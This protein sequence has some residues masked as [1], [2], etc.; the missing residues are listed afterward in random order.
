MTVKKLKELQTFLDKSGEKYE[1]ILV[2]LDPEND[3]A[4]DVATFRKRNKIEN[5]DWH[6]I[7]ADLEKTKVLTKQVGV[8]FWQYH[9]HIMHDF[10]ILAYRSGKLVK[11]INWE[12]RNEPIQLP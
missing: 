4:G 6:F 12:R 11:D 3:T 1:I 7:A 10:R 2:S 5:K 8:E 9:D